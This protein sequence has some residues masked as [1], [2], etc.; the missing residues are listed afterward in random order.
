MQSPA[1]LRRDRDDTSAVTM[2]DETRNGDLDLQ[3][4]ANSGELLG[5]AKPEDRLRST[6]HQ[7][8]K[9]SLPRHLISPPLAFAFA[10]SFAFAFAFVVVLALI[11]VVRGG[12]SATTI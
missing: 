6:R 8:G 10:F 12:R 11:F 9:Q 3:D 7:H 4:H 2:K 5:N 1:L